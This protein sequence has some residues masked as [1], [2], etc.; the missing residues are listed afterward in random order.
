MAE[1]VSSKC[2]FCEIAQERVFY[3]SPLVVGLWDGFPVSPG[4]A[5]LVSRRH[6]AS[7]FEASCDE[8][9]ALMEGIT[10][11]R[12]EICK[13]YQPDGFNIGVNVNQAAGQTIYH[14]HLHVIPRYQGDV[15]NPRGGVR[16]V[17][18]H[19]GDYRAHSPEGL[20]LLSGPPHMRPLVRGE[21]DP[22]LPHLLA[23]LDRAMAVDIAVAFVVR[24]GLRL[25]EEHLQE[26]LIR[27]GRIRFLTGDYLDVTEPEALLQLLDLYPSLDLRVFEALATSFHPKAFILHFADM[28]GTAYIGSSNLTETALKTGIEWNYR[29]VTSADRAGFNDV[30]AAFEALFSHSATRPVD[31]NWVKAY[32]KRRGLRSTIEV[33]VPKE[34][35]EPPPKPHGIQEE[36]LKALENTRQEGNTAGLVVLATGLGKTWLSAFDSSKPEFRR[37]L[38]VAHRDEIL[39]QAVKTFRRIRPEAT[40]GRY[41]GEKQQADAEVLF[42]SIMTIGRMRHLDRFPKDRFD[43]IIVDEF[44][45]AA[46]RTYRNLISYF[47]PRFLLGLTATPERTDG[48][49]LLTLCQENLVYRC[50]V[51]DG[52]DRG[53]LC[54][55]KYYGIPDEVDYSNIPWRSSRFDEEALTT[56]VATEKRAQNTLE[57]YQKLGQKRTLAFCCSHRHADFMADYFRR[58][59][60]R[61]VAVHSGPA[62]SPRAGSLKQLEAGNLDVVFAVDMFNEG[63]DVPNVDTVLMLRPTESSIL[64]QQ[65]F[66]RGLRKA[67]AKSH[68]TVID[69]I[70]NHRIFLTKVR[71]L[72]RL[73]IGDNHIDRILNLLVRGEASLPYGCEATYDLKAIEIIRSMLRP[74]TSVDVFKAYYL[75]FK[76]RQGVRPTAVEA[77]HDDYTPKSLRSHYVSWF[78]FVKSMGDLTTKQT[79]VLEEHGQFLDT[80]EVTAMTKSFKMLTLLAMLNQDCFPGQ[81]DIGK[82]MQGFRSLA[83]RSSVLRHDVGDALSDDSRLSQLIEE[84]PIQAWTGGRGT[85]GKKYFS[86]EDG[87]FRSNF[88]VRPEYRE[89]LQELVREIADWRL[90]EYLSRPGASASEPE[91]NQGFVCKASHS[92]GQPIIFLPGRNQNPNIPSGWTNITTS[93]G[94]FEA[95]FVKVALNVIRRRGSEFNELP[96]LLHK[97][98][99]PNAGKP[100]TRFKVAF[101]LEG[102]AWNMEPVRVERP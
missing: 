2:P 48:G 88:E 53:L 30:Q 41:D 44:H 59:G 94:D 39:G 77:F 27:G 66:G 70:G 71:S 49:D 76:E 61:S 64:W 95:N 36:A 100:G 14:L 57:Q 35:P 50:D 29:V 22:L 63:V 12:E 45:H 74:S 6:V 1:H 86:Y 97:W 92:G 26:L 75:D 18:P 25:V 67:V 72:F 91:G 79:A 4:H 101:K 15:A 33:V 82:L 16:Q 58:K 96:D 43:Y 51:F 10:R 56:A 55:F 78:Q 47:Q 24:S 20:E 11:V 73:G 31:E 40:I 93:E 38:F 7:W 98:F 60:V 65:Q 102:N 23:D 28:S 81:I 3:E 52:I 17:I 89:S 9:T 80:L 87:I 68:L 34:K 62:S 19:K 13:H 69:Y 21:N 8:R 99:G 90:A 84:N 37:V 5:L 42:A 83:Q 46:A 54:P 32:E 85:G